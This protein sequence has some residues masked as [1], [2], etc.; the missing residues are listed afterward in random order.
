MLLVQTDMEGGEQGLADL[1]DLDLDITD[2]PVLAGAQDGR[3][4]NDL[5]FS[6]GVQDGRLESDLQFSAGTQ[7]SPLESELQFAG[8]LYGG[9]DTLQV[10]DETSLQ[11][12]ALGK[13]TCCFMNLI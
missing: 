11:D 13:F 5:Q 10:E 6:A 8:A 2:T 12:K 3:Q 4:E 7:D 9:H 1:N